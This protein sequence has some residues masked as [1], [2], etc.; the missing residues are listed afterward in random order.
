MALSQAVIHDA[1]LKSQN[2]LDLAANIEAYRLQGRELARHLLEQDHI[3]P[4]DPLFGLLSALSVE[5]ETIKRG[6]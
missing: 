5:L 6:L 4:T 1:A 2:H 3:Q